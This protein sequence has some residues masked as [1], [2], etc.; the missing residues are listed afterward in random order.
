[1]KFNLTTTN[2]TGVQKPN[3]FLIKKGPNQIKK[4]PTTTNHVKSSSISNLSNPKSSKERSFPKAKRNLQN[5]NIFSKS[6]IAS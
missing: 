1:M 2:P 3:S 5:S 6:N 4:S